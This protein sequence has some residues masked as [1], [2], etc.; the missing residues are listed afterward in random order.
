[1]HG[2][3]EIKFEMSKNQWQKMSKAINIDTQTG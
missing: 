2:K 3:K 1:M